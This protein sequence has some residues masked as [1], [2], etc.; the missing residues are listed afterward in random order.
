METKKA[1]DKTY[2]LSD[3]RSGESLI[4]KTG[5]KG[6]ITIYNESS[7]TRRAI[8]HCP[9][10]K[11]VF[12]DEQDKFALVEPIIFE[13]GMLNVLANQPLTQKFLDMH[14]S[15]TANDGDGNWFEEVDD[16]IE[17]K[18]SLIDE[19]L[20][21]DVKSM[22][23]K[24][25]KE[26]DGIHRLSA[27][28]AVLKGSVAEAGKMGIEELKRELYNEVESDIDYFTNDLGDVTIFDN[29][30]IQRKYIILNGIREGILKKSANGKSILWTKDSKV[31][32]TA[33]RSVDTIDYFADYLTSDEG[34][35]VAEEIINRS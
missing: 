1:I 8:R 7:R 13:H 2:R 27:I 3:N 28:V 6:N 35:M 16:E 32:V 26:K 9:N 34:I 15:N 4:V 14:P 5:K 10:Q 33:P 20:R 30:D 22:I 17:A 23:R 11:S 19:E 25:A 12:M 31:I 24:V 18:E 29:E 21:L